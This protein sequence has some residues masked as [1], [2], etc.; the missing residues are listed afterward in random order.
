M[1]ALVGRA[2]VG[3]AS[4]APERLP[5]ATLL[6]ALYS[7]RSDRPVPK[8]QLQPLRSWPKVV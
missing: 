1:Y 4:V 5:K 7:V 3:R 8:Q 6:I 2:S